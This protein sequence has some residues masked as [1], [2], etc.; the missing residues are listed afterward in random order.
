MN[1]VSNAGGK[2]AYF[3]PDLAD[4]AVHRRVTQ[5]RHAG[6]EVHAFAF[7]RDPAMGDLP[8]YVS[9]GPLTH[10]SR[11]TRFVSLGRALAR[12]WHWRRTLTDAQLY[13]ARNM[14]NA[15]LALFVRKMTGSRVPIIYEVLDING[16]CVGS[17]PSAQLMRRLERWLLSRIS[18]LVV[19]SP[20]YMSAYYL[21]CFG[22]DG[23]WLL[24]ENKIPQHACA[25]H[26]VIDQAPRSDSWKIG[27]FGFLDDD[28]SWRA[29]CNLAERMPKDVMIY[30]RGRPYGDFDTEGFLDDVAR[31]HNVVYGGPYK[32]PDELSAIYGAVD[33]VWSADLNALD[34][35][36]RW[37]LTNAT[38]EALYFGKPLISL[39]STAVGEFVAEHDAGWCIEEPVEDALID[40]FTHL[41]EDQYRA[42][43][44]TIAAIPR[45]RFVESDE[46]E[47]I[48]RIS[49]VGSP[50]TLAAPAIATGSS[51]IPQL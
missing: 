8:G 39:S 16:S 11:L 29:L 51:E 12:L 33:I 5:W 44:A 47:R 28:R 21:P 25:V 35:N 14:D 37:L 34:G 6:H 23:P 24:F 49:Q 32:S 41:S 38:Y 18:L 50:M 19:S 31:L 15:F 46:I 22:Y 48:F 27:W 20:Y 10:R 2:V 1:H 43:C 17:G 36:S 4:P 30:V 45:D 7:A 26:K 9:L 42:K 3:A 40:L 13:I